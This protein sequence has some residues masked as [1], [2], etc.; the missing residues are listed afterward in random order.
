MRYSDPAYIDHNTFPE[1]L[2][3]TF[4]HIDYRWGYEVTYAGN[5]HAHGD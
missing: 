4:N 3:L 5:A 1:Y 2:H